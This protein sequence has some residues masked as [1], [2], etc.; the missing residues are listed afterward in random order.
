M[1]VY[2]NGEYID[3]SQATVSIK[4]RGFT[5][6]DGLFET[7]YYDGRS[8]ECLKPHFE[9]LNKGAQL[10]QIPFNL[11]FSEFKDT[12][13]K[14]IDHNQ[15]QGISA[16]LRFTLTRGPS[17]RGIQLP[18]T[19]IPTTLATVVPY[20]RRSSLLHLGFS[21]YCFQQAEPL[22]SVKHLGYQLAILGRLEADQRGLDDVLFFNRQGYLVGASTANVFVFKGGQLITPPLTDGCLPGIMRGKIIAE[23]CKSK[24]PVRVDHLTRQDVEV[25]ER[26]FLTNSLIG[27][28]P[29]VMA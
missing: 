10:F 9:R 28:V 13:L 25:A 26:I 11:L 6:G 23:M 12:L 17:E 14:L 18:E 22:C 19:V 15:L 21:Q 27:S 24:T 1:I 29:G 2:L 3:A 16:A 5:L 20:Q 8:I 4:D 7:L